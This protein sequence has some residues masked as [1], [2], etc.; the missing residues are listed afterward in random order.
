[1]NLE[2]EFN[3]CPCCGSTRTVSDEVIKMDKVKQPP[4][5]KFGTELKSSALVNPATM[6]GRLTVPVLNVVT[7]ICFDCGAIYAK[8]INGHN[9]LLSNLQQPGQPKMPP[10]FLK[11]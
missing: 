9:E 4:N 2:K 10:G 6:A 1:M 8:Y 11:G 5:A 3:K 7:D